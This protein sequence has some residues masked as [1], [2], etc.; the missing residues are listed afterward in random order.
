MNAVH[1][2]TSEECLAFLSDLKNAPWQDGSKSTTGGS[3]K[4]KNNLQ[5][6]PPAKEI[7]NIIR[8][9]NQRIESP[10]FRYTFFP[11]ELIGLRVAKYGPGCKY[12]WHVDQ[13]IMGRKSVHMSFTIFLNEGYEGGELEI[14]SPQPHPPILIKKSPGEGVIYPT[15]VRHR[16]KP[17][18]SGERIV[19]VGWIK[20]FIP[21]YEKRIVFAR[22]WNIA[23]T[24]RVEANPISSEFNEIFLD[25]IRTSV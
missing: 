23:C 9:I 1:L 4:R 14:M 25:L 7:K 5:L 21:S 11:K 18:L 13:A 8:T 24:L 16:V 6:F 2:F 12:D 10:L 20:S 17:V 3:E 15:S 19:L 22:L